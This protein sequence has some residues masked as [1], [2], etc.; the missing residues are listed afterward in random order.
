MSVEF[1]R[2][3]QNFVNAIAGPFGGS[4]DGLN[5]LS[6]NDYSNGGQ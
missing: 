6:A 5:T 1:L 4:I 2:A 3:L